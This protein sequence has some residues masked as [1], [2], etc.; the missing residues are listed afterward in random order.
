[1]HTDTCPHTQHFFPV[2]TIQ[3][4]LSKTQQILSLRKFSLQRCISTCIYLWVQSLVLASSPPWNMLTLI[5]TTHEKYCCVWIHLL[6]CNGELLWG[7]CWIF[8]IG[9][10][11]FA[12]SLYPTVLNLCSNFSCLISP[13]AMPTILGF[14][15]TCSATCRCP[16]LLG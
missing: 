2:C 15:T 4:S 7:L 3:Q 6:L 9:L 1:M 12:S 14:P 8:F 10:L 16:A 13:Q 11:S 5:K